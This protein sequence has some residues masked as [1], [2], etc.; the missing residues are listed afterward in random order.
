MR[1][2]LALFAAG[3]LAMGV[4]QGITISMLNTF[5]L[6]QTPPA[7]G[8]GP[9][10][11][12]AAT[13]FGGAITVH[14]LGVVFAFNSPTATAIYGD[15]IG[16]TGNGIDPPFTDPLLDG[17]SDGTLTLNFDSS[18][19]FISF[20]ILLALMPGN[21]G[22]T[23]T[24]GGIANSFTTV[25]GQ[26]SGGFFSVGHVDLTP[27]SPFSQAVITFDP[28]DPTVQFAIDNLAYNVDPPDSTSAPEPA[29][30]GLLGAGLLLMGV[31][32][33]RTTKRR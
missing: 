6:G 11:P 8:L 26:G 21:S 25:G 29:V 15:S 3:G 20:D 33:R 23:I 18:T 1:R 4:A 13:T 28:N 24:L 7:G 12:L 22:G 31:F 16:T 10:A 30:S 17:P 5:S 32:R 27:A 19:T 14:S 2:L 9:A